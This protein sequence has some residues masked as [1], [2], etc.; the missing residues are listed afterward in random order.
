MIGMSY[1]IAGYRCS[2]EPHENM[3]VHLNCLRFLHLTL[4][5]YGSSARKYAEK[6]L[7]HF[8]AMARKLGCN[9]I[10]IVRSLNPMYYKIVRVISSA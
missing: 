4:Y 7:E 2:R 6:H 3:V 5:N 8:R 10:V 9:T 1:L